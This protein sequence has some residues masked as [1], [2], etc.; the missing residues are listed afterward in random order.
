MLMP[1]MARCRAS[2]LHGRPSCA[3]SRRPGLGGAWF[4]D[5]L[6][7]SPVVVTNLSGIY[8]DHLAQHVMGFVLAFARRFDHYLPRQ[9]DGVWKRDQPMLDLASMTALVVGVG[10]AG[11]EAAR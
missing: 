9:K 2:C 10:G 7:K 6:V 4:Y 11:S 1:P 5:D 8:N 3:G